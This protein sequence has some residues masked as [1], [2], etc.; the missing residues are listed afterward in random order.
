LLNFKKSKEVDGFKK[1]PYQT[2]AFF[3]KGE[4]GDWRNHLTEAQRDSVMG[5]VLLTTISRVA[6]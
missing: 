4:V 5:T 6:F 1:R 2:V 3:R